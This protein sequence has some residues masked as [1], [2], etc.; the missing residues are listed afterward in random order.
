MTTTTAVRRLYSI[1][2]IVERLGVGRTTVYG[3]VNAGELERVKIGRRSLVT[4]DSLEDYI[5]SLTRGD[6]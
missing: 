1:A 4:G 3:L 2:E 5:S 6:R